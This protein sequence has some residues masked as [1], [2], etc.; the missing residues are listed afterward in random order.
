MAASPPVELLAENHNSSRS[1]TTSIF[2]GDGIIVGGAGFIALTENHGLNWTTSSSGTMANLFGVDFLDS[3]TVIVVGDSGTVLKSTDGGNNFV[4][5]QGVPATRGL[6]TVVFFDENTGVIFGNGETALRST[7]AGSSWTT[8]I[9]D[10]TD[11]PT[12]TPVERGAVDYN[13]SKSNTTSIFTGDGIMVGDAGFIA[14]TENHGQDWTT[15]GSGPNANLFGVGYFDSTTVVVA[16]AGG[17]VAISYDGG[18]NF[19]LVDGIP[20]TVDLTDVFFTDSARGIIVGNSGVI[21]RTPEADIVVMVPDIFSDPGDTV[22][23]PMAM[24]GAQGVD[25]F[26]FQFDLLFT[27]TMLEADTAYIDGTTLPGEEGWLFEFEASNN[28][29]T[30]VAAG[31]DPLGPDGILLYAVFNVAE[32]AQNNDS[33]PIAFANF[34]FNAGNPAPSQLIDGSV[35]VVVPG[36]D[37]DSNVIVQAFDASMVLRYLAGDIELSLWQQLEAEV[38]ANGQI[39]ELDA[40]LILQYVAGII[41][42]FPSQCLITAPLANGNLSI[43]ETIDATS[44]EVVIPIFIT[45]AETVFSAS[46]EVVYDSEVLQLTEIRTTPATGSFMTAHNA[47]DGEADIFLAGA[48]E[49]EGDHELV[50]MVFTLLSQQAQQTQVIL[51]SARLNENL[52]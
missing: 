21:L 29:L 16:G 6:N 37:V 46:F 19:Q 51:A 38:S 47:I 14:R 44:E 20:T 28:M 32:D 8:F 24:R 3:N 9:I 2:T 31:A 13:S 27:G 5:I 43:P 36:G 25:I 48:S 7:N 11:M 17:T 35:T 1:N 42:C 49:V 50:E 33:S 22:T 45:D 41:V 40:S 39:T 18:N 34:L 26:S 52:I 12:S 15:S 10:T 4:K 30:I 23:I